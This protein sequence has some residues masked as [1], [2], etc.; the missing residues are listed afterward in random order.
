MLVS[1][2]FQLFEWAGE[3]LKYPEITI[4]GDFQPKLP[5][6]PDF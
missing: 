4:L 6:I 2:I 3:L 1:D 5:V